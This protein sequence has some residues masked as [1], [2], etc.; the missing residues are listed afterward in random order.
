MACVYLHIFLRRNKESRKL[1]SPPGA[2][3]YEDTAT[4]KIVAGTWRN[5]GTNL[6][7]LQNIPRNSA[8]RAKEVKDE[9]MNYFMTDQGR[10]LARCIFINKI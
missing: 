1:Y 4:G 10:H 6:T 2:F 8:T 9:F 7:G 5:D 3:D